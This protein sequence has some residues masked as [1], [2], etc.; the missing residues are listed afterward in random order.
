MEVEIKE[1]IDRL[2]VEIAL[3]PTGETRNLLTDSNIML[4][5]LL[6]KEKTDQRIRSQCK[7]LSNKL[8]DFWKND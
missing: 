5:L 1:L 4:R 6:E 7:E 3:T 8:D 2:E